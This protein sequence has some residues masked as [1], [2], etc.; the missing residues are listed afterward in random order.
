[1]LT[2]PFMHSRGT[3]SLSFSQARTAD[4]GFV[5]DKFRQVADC[6]DADNS[7]YA[8]PVHNLSHFRRPMASSVISSVKLP[9]AS[10][11]PTMPQR[12]AAT[13]PRTAPAGA[14]SRTRRRNS[15]NAH[16]SQGGSPLFDFFSLYVFILV[17]SVFISSYVFFS[18]YFFIWFLQSLFLH[19]CSSVF[20]ISS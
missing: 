3:Q 6:F 8:F 10:T 15:A 19:M 12:Q 14:T 11:P 20:R 18:L 4:Y 13:A 16:P 2:T 17:S 9:T 7:I 5:C 1:M